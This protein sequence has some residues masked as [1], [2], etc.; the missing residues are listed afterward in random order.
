[1][2]DLLLQFQWKHNFLIQ[3]SASISWGSWRS[4]FAKA[5]PSQIPSAYR[6]AG[7]E[8]IVLGQ[9]RVR[10]GS[11][12]GRARAKEEIKKDL[13]VLILSNHALTEIAIKCH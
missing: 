2:N 7:L 5:P 11:H 10:P 8:K 4:G 1:M 6:F 13:T 9:T 12:P 3:A